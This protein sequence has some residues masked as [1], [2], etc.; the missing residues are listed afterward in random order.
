MG[1]PDP[2]AVGRSGRQPAMKRQLSKCGSA[3]GQMRRQLGKHVARVG[4][5]IELDAVRTRAID[6]FRP[7]SIPCL[8]PTR[9]Q[10]GVARGDSNQK[11][12]RNTDRR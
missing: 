6:R 1:W 3:A 5:R 7:Q 10:V 12:V 11:R 4:I 8:L 2:Y 9:D